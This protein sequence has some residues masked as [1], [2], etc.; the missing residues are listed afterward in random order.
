MWRSDRGATSLLFAA[1]VLPLIVLGLSV[2]VEISEYFNSLRIVQ[3]IVDG[4]CRNGLTRHR[5]E[6][7][8]KAAIESQVESRKIDTTIASVLKVEGAGTIGLT[9]VGE[10]R[11][12]VLLS[13]F[14]HLFGSKAEALPFRVSASMREAKSASLLLL[15]RSV[16]DAAGRCSDATLVTIERFAELLAS[17]LAAA[18]SVHLNVQAFPA[19]SGGVAEVVSEV[20]GADEFVRCRSVGAQGSPSLLFALEGDLA[21][22]LDRLTFVDN[23]THNVTANVLSQGAELSSIT[24]LIRNQ[25]YEAGLGEELLD[26]LGSEAFRQRKRLRVLMVVVGVSDPREEKRELRREFGAATHLLFVNERDLNEPQLVHA[27]SRMVVGR[28]VIER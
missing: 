28:S 16:S 8:L 20:S 21:A 26:A 23:V 19:Q 2:V 11:G 14:N 10:Y 12:K 18:R 7:E 22:R 3:E 4:E 6:A 9:L 25:H 1:V 17:E 13:L 5:T 15:D 27:I 24:I